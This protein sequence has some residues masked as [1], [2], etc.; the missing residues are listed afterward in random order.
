MPEQ[1]K[2][3]LRLILYRLRHLDELKRFLETKE[4]QYTIIGLILINALTIGLETSPSITNSVGPWLTQIDKY[5]L[6][7][8]TLE[9]SLKIVA[10]RH[11]FFTNAWNLFDFL[12]VAIALIPAAGPLHILRTL[13]IL[14]TARL[15][16]NVPK[17]RLIIESLLKSIPSIGWIAVLLFMIFYIFAVIGTDLYQDEFPQWFG[18]LGK[19]FFTLFQIMTLE[20]WSTGIARPMMEVLPHSYLFFVPFILLATYTTLNVF[21]AIVVNTMNELNR[22]EMKDDETRTREL[23][24]EEHHEILSYL[25]SIQ[26]KMNSLEKRL[27]EKEQDSEVQ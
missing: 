4:F 10:Y 23:I 1:S 8:F 17:L 12:I 25:K 13:R 16:K 5:I 3:P 27:D 14:R 6:I 15:I 20:S 21:I 18:D 19:T 9:I 26:R 22:A 11:R 24:H 2:N 7:V